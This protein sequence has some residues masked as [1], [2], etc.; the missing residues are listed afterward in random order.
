MEIQITSRNITVRRLLRT[1][2]IGT[3]GTALQR[4][5]ASIAVARV[6]LSDRNGRRGGGDKRCRIRLQLMAGQPVL[7]EDVEANPRRAILHAAARAQA[8]VRSQLRAAR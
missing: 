1:F 6:E 5:V 4:F 2:I 3:L 8:A 7:V